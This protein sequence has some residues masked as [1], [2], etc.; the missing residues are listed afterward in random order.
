MIARVPL[1]SR[2]VA[3]WLRRVLG[4]LLPVD[5]FTSGDRR[6]VFVIWTAGVIQGFAQSQ[7]AATLPFTRAGLG[8]TEGEMSLLLG[9]A[10]L[11]AFAALPLGWLGDHKG[12]RRPFLWSLTIV[13]IGGTLAG[14]AFEAWQ[15]G[16]AQAI[17]RTGTAGMGGLAIVLLA[18]QVS[19]HIRAY[20]ISFYG[21]AVSFGGGLA[22]MTL[23]LADGGGES[24]RIP[25]LMIA[26]GFL[27]LP[28]VIRN[29]PESHIFIEDH[30]DRHWRELAIGEWARRFWVV[31]I[32]AFLVSAFSAVALAFSTT[33]LIEY[34]GLSTGSTVLIALLGGTLGG[35]GFFVGG[36]LADAWGRR[37]TTVVSLLLAVGGGLVIYWSNSIPWIVVAVM[38]SS[39][40]TFALVP[41]GGSHRAE[42][43]PTGLR[44]SANT[45]ATNFGLVGSG[46][47]LILGVFTIDRFGL[48]QTVT[49]LGLGMGIAALLTLL[50]P[51]TRGQDLRAVRTAR[52]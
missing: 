11:A 44:A 35:L 15:F 18:E 49:I 14:L 3:P 47:G 4:P 9:L 23:P 12:R 50:L 46:L 51:E 29:V 16:T 7:A 20:A 45:A 40:G 8:L 26:L 17:L 32:I 43:F 34:L 36:H 2:L 39:F 24:W 30:E 28:F 19:P 6:I 41:A 37:R 38:V 52:L 42:L 21:A 33:R 25:H 27:V 22:L 1:Y 5:R 48:S 13:I 10:R 31:V